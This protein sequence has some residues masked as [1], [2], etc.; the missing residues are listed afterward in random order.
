MYGVS[1]KKFLTVIITTAFAAGAIYMFSGTIVSS[2]SASVDDYQKWIA[3]TYDFRFGHDRPFAP[4]NATTVSGNFIKPEK[5]TASQRCVAC[6]TDIHP[7]WRESAH[8]NA[9]REPFYQKNVNDLT[10]KRNIAFTR[11]CESCHNPAALFSGALTDKPRFKDRPF[12]DDGVSCIACHSIQSVSGRGVGGYTMAEPALLVSES[13]ERIS[14]PTDQDILEDV[15]A[16]KRALMND[17]LKKPEFC[18]AC[19]KSQVPKELN[20]YKFLRA[21]AV[22]D[23]LQMSSFSKESPHPYYVR[24]KQSCNSCHMVKVDAKFSD[25][26]AKGGV[27]SSHRFAAANTAIPTFYGYR[28]QLKE[29]ETFLK[30]DRL[31]IDIFALRR[32][33]GNGGSEELIAPVNRRNFKLGTGDVITADVVV[34]NKNIGHSFPPELRDFYEAYIEFY[35]TDG[36]GKPLYKSGFIKPDG[37]LDEFAHDY[38]TY[39]VRPDGSSN[40]LHHIWETR[41]IPQNLAIQSGRSDVARYRFAIPAELTGNIKISARLQYRRFTRVFSDYVLGKSV[42]YPIVTMAATEKMLNIGDNASAQP[43]PKAMPDWRRWN[44]Y[45]IALLDQRQFAAAADAFAKAAELDEKYR[46]FALTNRALAFMEIDRWVEARKLIDTALE[47]D[48]ANYR[49]LYQRG[50]INRVESKLAQAEADFKKVN[51]AFP[52]DRLT[53]QQL[54]ELS[55]I[56]NDYSTA[57]GYFQQILSID[58]EDVG[59]HYNMMLLYRKTG[60]KADAEREEK[61]FLDLKEDPR[62]TALAAD[63]LQRNPSVGRRSLPYYVNDLKPF[64]SD[65][66][67]SGYLAV[68]GLQ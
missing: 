25:I 37:Y 52:R 24:D 66:E 7:Q 9:F 20:D 17:V 12:D 32:V 8:A 10:T 56:R 3:E 55:K 34:T 44:N 60:M 38:K 30:D 65:L 62:T 63:F 11:H 29:V 40:E 42:D 16:H 68:F 1:A 53:L 14:N 47:L 15:P 46:P 48:P 57:I 22:G 26:A 51:S 23:E 54:G 36:A 13:G 5:F 33:P 35:V 31:G 58:P 4:S 61:T 28:D 2:R 45:G 49:A 50:R 27:V 18:A 6:H 41:V 59:S 43:D 39:L 64:R 19:H 67:K 21:F